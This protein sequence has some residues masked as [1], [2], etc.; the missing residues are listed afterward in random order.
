MLTGSTSSARH[1]LTGG[2]VDNVTAQS[3]LL[4]VHSCCRLGRS[5]NPPSFSLRKILC[6][7]GVALGIAA[8]FGYWQV[9]V[10]IGVLAGVVLISAALRRWWHFEVEAHWREGALLAEAEYQLLHSTPSSAI[11]RT[12]LNP[13][14]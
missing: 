10:A 6:G 4:Y 3:S 11:D 13:P 2:P 5:A 8:A 7:V 12:R 9:L 1:S 14:A